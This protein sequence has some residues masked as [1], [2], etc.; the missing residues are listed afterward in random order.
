MS[1]SHE[2]VKIELLNAIKNHE[3]ILYYQPQFNLSTTKF[4]SVEALIRWQHP[5]KGLLLPNDF[6]PIAEESGLIVKIGEWSI[7]KACLQNKLWRDKGLPAIRIAVNVSG[8]QLQQRDFVE[9]IMNSLQEAN[10]EAHY[11]ELEL[12]ENIIIHDNNKKLISAIQ[13]LK[14]LGVRLALDDFGTG[15]S[16]ISHLK[17]IPIDRIKI[18]KTYIKNINVNNDDTAIV[19]AIISLA[20]SLNIQVLAEGVESLKQLNT[21]L[22]HECQE[23]QGFYFSEPLPAEGVEKFLLFYQNKQFI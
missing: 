22:A 13:R 12:T 21:L 18:D 11:L 1:I 9:F 20:A 3:L 5:V 8:R 6:I 7:K 23:A 4:E 10:V 19:K 2:R 16:S 15:Y 17:K 14:K